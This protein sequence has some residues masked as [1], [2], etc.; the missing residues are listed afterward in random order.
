M[1]EIV[2]EISGIIM[3]VCFMLCYVPQIMKIFKNRSSKDVSLGLIT[4]SI[5]GYVAGMIYL[6]TGTF[7]VW[8]LLNYL[9]GIIM[10]LI[11]IYAWCKYKD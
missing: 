9:N 7:G 4:M 8:W 1:K 3:T 10:C 5:C 11:L 2:R 6:F